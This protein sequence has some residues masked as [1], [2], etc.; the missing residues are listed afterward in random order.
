MTLAAS[1]RASSSASKTPAV[2]RAEGLV[3]AVLYGRDFPNLHL[4]VPLKEFR[5]V[6]GEA[7]ENTVITLTI[8]D[9]SYPALI[10]DHQSDPLSREVR[11]IDFYRVRMD[12]RITA[13]VPLIV[14]GESPAVKELGG[15]LLRAMD[16]VEVEAL[17][18][19]LPREL[20]LDVSG[21][22]ELGASLFV[23]DIPI[24]GEFTFVVDPETVV[25]TVAAPNEEEVVAAPASIEDVVV[26]SE[27]KK[28]ARQAE[29]EATE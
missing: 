25:L 26:E 27:V 14:T 20:Y 29:R 3:P 5:R 4:A 17:P 28:A 23:R 21:I 7:G 8:G 16:E 22:T 10:Y 15:V 24:T 9:D 11:H 12:E 1:L 6:W 19:N 2:L 13:P 18:A